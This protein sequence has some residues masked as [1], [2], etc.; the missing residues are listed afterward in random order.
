VRVLV[1]Q[2]YGEPPHAKKAVRTWGAACCA[3]TESLRQSEMLRA[4]VGATRQKGARVGRRPHSKG[5]PT[6]APHPA[7]S[8]L[9]KR[10]L[11]SRGCSAPDENPRH[12]RASPLQL[13]PRLRPN[14]TAIVRSCYI[15]RQAKR[16]GFRH[17]AAARHRRAPKESARR[18]AESWQRRNFLFRTYRRSGPFRF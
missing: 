11:S 10:V 1:Y 8:A 9:D 16:H 3:P 15:P 4:A 18:P 13:L 7:S 14:Y 6:P 2:I 5:Q 17:S 12:P